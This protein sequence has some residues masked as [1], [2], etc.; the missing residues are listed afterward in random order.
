MNR[1][2]CIVAFVFITKATVAQEPSEIETRERIS[3]HIARPTHGSPRANAAAAQP[4]LPIW[5]YQ[6]VSPLTG[7]AYGGYMV[8]ANPF[9]R[10]A[11]ATTIPVVLVPFRV[12][13][14]NTTSGFTATFDPSTAPDAAC[15]AG[16]TA[17]SLVENSP[18]F[19][20]RPWTLNGVDVGT[21]QYLDAFQRSNFW[22]YVQNTGDA[23]HTLLS[24][25]VGEPLTLP[26]R[27]A[28]AALA[29]EVRVGAPTSCTNPDGAGA[30]NGAAYQGIVDFN[31]LVGA[32]TGYIASHQITP[33]QF[34]I[35]ILYN[36]EYSQNGLIYLGGY[37]F[38]EASYPQALI[39]PGQT[40]AMAN[41]RTNGT[42]PFDV[43]ILS[44]EIAEWMDDPGG[45]NAVPAWGNIG[46]VTGCKR[47]LEVGDP[48]TETD[49]PPI[50]GPNGFAYHLQ[51]LA[52]FSWFLRIPSISA[53]GLMSDNGTLTTNAG[54]VC[55]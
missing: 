33:D 2:A 52:Y 8:G 32:M 53:G 38:S 54:P 46:E 31:V 3:A 6:T 21:T 28:S 36:V 14:T 24:W 37:H 39:S 29:A 5:T 50:S 48:L 44:H 49:L 45:Y 35:F 47:A 11:R 43:S 9:F 51:E 7:S 27:Y 41:F 55:Q 30:I 26:I 18:I 13:F 4:Q 42:G 20:S 34:P 22:Q 19:Q 17:M 16:Q 23:Y 10:G 1:L 25:T 40:F 15:T 12:E